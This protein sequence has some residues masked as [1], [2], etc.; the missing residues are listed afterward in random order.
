MMRDRGVGVLGGRRR[1]KVD[2]PLWRCPVKSFIPRHIS[3]K[4]QQQLDVHVQGLSYLRSP[5][6]V[7]YFY[8]LPRLY[9]KVAYWRPIS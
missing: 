8:S 5:T 2:C 3:S 7:V 4:P 9:L 6:R 1:Q